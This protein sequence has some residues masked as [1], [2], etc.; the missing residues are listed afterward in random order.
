MVLLTN[1]YVDGRSN[2]MGTSIANLVDKVITL[3][4]IL[5]YW[6]NG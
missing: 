1:I 2:C 4:S 5:I 3:N 6:L